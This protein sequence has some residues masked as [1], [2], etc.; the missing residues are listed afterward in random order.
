MSRFVKIFVVF[1][2]IITLLPR[3]FGY[4]TIPLQTKLRYAAQICNTYSPPPEMPEFPEF[5]S[6]KWY[7]VPLYL[8]DGADVNLQFFSWSV[9]LIHWLLDDLRITVRL[10]RLFI[11]NSY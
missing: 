8:F 11:L 7:E 6:Y 4:S 1:M 2:L 9:N 3:V 10:V 5:A